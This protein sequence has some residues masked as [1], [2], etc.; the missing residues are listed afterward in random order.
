MLVEEEGTS[1]AYNPIAT[2]DKN[3]ED[4]V[5]R[6][7]DLARIIGQYVFFF[8]VVSSVSINAAFPILLYTFPLLFQHKII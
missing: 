8:K 4:Q 6:R 2:D 3:K 5:L 7:G 1:K